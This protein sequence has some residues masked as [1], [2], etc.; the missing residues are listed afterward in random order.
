VL[1]TPISAGGGR[2][3]SRCSGELDR[4]GR[5]RL[6][7]AV[8]TLE[9]RQGPHAQR[10][11]TFEGAALGWYE[12]TITGLLESVSEPPAGDPTA[13]RLRKELGLKR[14]TTPYRIKVVEQPEP[15][16]Y[17]I[18]LET[19]LGKGKAQEGVKK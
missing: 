10:I 19:Y 12:V 2:Y 11:D 6:V 3:S 14:R 17:D 16:H 7:T 15:G 9:P 13:D 1:Y 5:Y 4:N 8:R 18:K